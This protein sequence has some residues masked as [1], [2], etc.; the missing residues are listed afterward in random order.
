MLIYV[1][2]EINALETRVA[3]DP[4]SVA[5]LLKLG[6]SVSIETGAGNAAGHLDADYTAAGASIS[7]DRNSSLGSADFV[8]RVLPADLA[9]I[10]LQKP[11]S[12]ATGLMDPFGS[13]ERI[14][15]Y[16][17][18]KVSALCSEL[19]PRST[20]AQ[21]MDVLSS[22]ANLAGYMS[23]IT[24]S[25]Q[26]D[27]ILPMMMTPAGTISPAKVFIIGVGVAGLQAIATARRLGARVEAFDTRPVVEEQ[28]KSL[29]AKFV[30]IDIGEVGQTEQGYAKELTPEQVELQRT[31]MAKV[32]SSSDIVITTAK[33]FGRKAPVLLTSQMI[34]GMRPGSI[35]VD[36]AAEGGGNVEGTVSNEE[37]V[38]DGGVRIIGW[39]ALERKV[40]RHASQMFSANMFNLIEHFWDG[41]A[42]E[43][44]LKTEDEIIKGCLLTHDGAIVHERFTS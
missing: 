22:Q 33:V 43:F 42:K 7:T 41:E 36:L 5:K 39:N 28:V 44:P 17:A 9:E 30:K 3:L 24:A 16:A 20:L 23:V 15:A 38:T 18:A 40:P 26:L 35:I 4:V 11:G 10:A 25:E 2:R 12:M 34:S 1:P 14:E 13:R 31:G 32:C 19:I 27:S 21:K 8:I 37:I 29:G 6:A